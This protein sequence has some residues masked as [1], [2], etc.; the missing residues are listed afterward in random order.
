MI[1]IKPHQ[2]QPQDDSYLLI[3]IFDLFHLLKRRVAFILG[4]CAVFI[5]AMAIYIYTRGQPPQE[6]KYYRLTSY[7]EILP[8]YPADIAQFIKKQA[9]FWALSGKRDELGTATSPSALREFSFNSVIREILSY[10]QRQNFLDRVDYYRTLVAHNEGDIEA[11]TSLAINSSVFDIRLPNNQNIE[12]TPVFI[13]YS[14]LVPGVAQ[15]AL[16]E[17]LEQINTAVNAIINDSLNVAI[18]TEIEIQ[19]TRQRISVDDVAGSGLTESS[20]GPKHVDYQFS[21]RTIQ[22]LKD[23]R[24]VTPVGRTFNYRNK[25]VT[26]YYADTKPIST[27]KGSKRLF[28]LALSALVGLMMGC[29]IVIINHSYRRRHHNDSYKI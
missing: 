5:A 15:Q 7:A 14:T 28:L 25:P 2:V 10:P 13:S 16:G 4:V 26:E 12:I 21:T 22:A 19:Q 17:F 20:S 27:N 11:L 1:P 6:V 23:L 24:A 18:D 3:D 29:A 9:E 8:S